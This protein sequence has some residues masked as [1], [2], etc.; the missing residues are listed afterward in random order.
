MRFVPAFALAAALTAT[1]QVPSFVPLGNGDIG[2]S[3]RLEDG[4]D[5]VLYV[6][7]SDSWSET[8]RLLKLARVR[9]RLKPGVSGGQKLDLRTAEMTAE[10]PAGIIR[11]WVDANYPIIRVEAET[12]KPA[13]M[14]VVLERWRDQPRLL[15]GAD[16]Q[17]AGLEGTPEPVMSYGD[18]VVL[19]ARNSVIAYHRNPKS[20][21]GPSLRL[22]GNGDFA[23]TYTDPLQ[24]RTF[25][26]SVQG[27]GL[28]RM[29]P[30]T[31]RSG[32]PAQKHLVTI[33]ALTA[34]TDSSEEWIR[35]IGVLVNKMAALPAESARTGHRKWWSDFWERSHVHLT[36]SAEAERISRGY[37]MQRYLNACAG[38][39][40]FPI[41]SNGSLFSIGDAEHH[42][43]FRPGA[44]Y[45]LRST[46]D[47]Y[48]SMLAS[49]DFDLMLPLFRMYREAQ[50]LAEKRTSAWFQH[51]GAFF[52]ESM[53]FWGAYTPAAYG[54]NRQGR[55]ASYVDDKTQRREFGANIELLQL[56]LEYASYSQDKN[57]T[58]SVAPSL[59][60]AILDFF[61]SKERPAALRPVLNELVESKPPLTKATMDKAR[62]MLQQMSSVDAPPQAPISREKIAENLTGELP[63]DH[64]SAGVA[65]RALQV[66]LVEAQNG[67]LYIGRNLPK[68]W[69]AEFKLWAPENTV[70]EGVIKAG[71][72]E[73]LKVTPD[74]RTG[75]IIRPEEKS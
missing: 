31:L 32:S 60:G 61:D 10:G 43:D 5:V 67:K 25:G 42:P 24:N 37:E 54:W 55:P 40:A 58:R 44:V 52:P 57:F 23:T 64:A 63:I 59:I 28:S 2:V 6:A 4:G 71:R 48:R 47:L 75:D 69:D 3:A 11:A 14:Q 45:N 19:E 33:V 56:M 65:A 50:A 34:I 49:G 20:V 68:D 73:K 41:H 38:R 18:T 9:V 7:K 12:S 17:N 13:E 36:G 53:Y 27:E 66:M 35:Q 16:L 39:G 62:R 21:W 22:Q 51:S 8:A 15:E 70:V 46:H 29:N 1:A 26:V 72:I 30:T 74:K